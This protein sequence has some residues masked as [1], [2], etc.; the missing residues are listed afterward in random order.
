MAKDG[1]TKE[2]KKPTDLKKMKTEMPKAAE[3]AE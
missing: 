2:P 3:T 1:T